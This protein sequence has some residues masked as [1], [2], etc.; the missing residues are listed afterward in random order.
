MD[1]PASDSGRGVWWGILVA[2]L[3]VST[4]RAQEPNPGTRASGTAVA[5][6]PSLTPGQHL[7]VT[8]ASSAFTGVTVGNLVKVAA[9]RLT[10]VDPERG[11]VTELPLGS[12]TRIEVGIERRKTKKWFLI[13]LGL[14]AIG[15]IA[16]AADD[17]E[18]CGGWDEPYHECSSNEKVA[19]AASSLAVWGG[20]GALFGHTR[21]AIEWSNVPLERVKV[22]VRP[23]RGGGRIGFAFSF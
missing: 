14:G 12:V 10:L 16:I 7:R 21:K 22:S 2:V 18:S 3:A 8:A 11:S 4:A 19:L 15:A 9:D 17:S 6:A 13:G 1:Y 20:L 5:E 23:E